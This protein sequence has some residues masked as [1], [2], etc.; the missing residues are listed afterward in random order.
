MKKVL[1]H[2][3]G[4]EEELHAAYYYQEYYGLHLADTWN[5]NLGSKKHL[6]IIMVD[7]NGDI[8]IW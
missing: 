6:R 7:E 4:C 5:T 1:P 2:C 8:K 3:Q